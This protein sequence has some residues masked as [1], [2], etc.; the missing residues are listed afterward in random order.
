VALGHDAAAAD[1]REPAPLDRPGLDLAQPGVPG[2]VLDVIRSHERP[3]EPRA[4]QPR[5]A[6]PDLL[7]AQR[8]PR[9]LELD[10]GAAFRGQQFPGPA[11]Q[12]GRIAADPDVPVREQH[13]HPPAR[14]RD[15][16][17]HVPQHDQRP[18]RAG[19]VDGVRRDVDAQGGDTPLGQGHG[20][21]ARPRADVKG[22]TLAAVQERLVAGAL[23]QPALHRK[24]HAA[25][26]GAL[27]L[28]PHPAGQRVLVKL[29]DHADSLVILIRDENT[30][31][32]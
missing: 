27:D 9:R 17:E 32:C 1:R 5:V 21:P 2:H 6:Q 19:Q 8:R 29:P 25:A 20:Q 31:Q 16:A 7:A 28:R 13:G 22:R 10:Q 30:H 12:R 14:A 3:R 23:A 26:V 24:R 15:A 18:G 4:G 11:Q